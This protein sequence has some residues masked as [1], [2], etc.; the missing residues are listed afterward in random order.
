VY[1]N[2]NKKV[3]YL[4]AFRSSGNMSIHNNFF[5]ISGYKKGLEVLLDSLILSNCGHLIRSSSNVGAAAQFLNLNLTH[6][7]VNELEAGDC[8]EQ[9]Y[10]L[11]SM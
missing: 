3:I 7:N 10:N 11:Y 9:E 8:R 2:L 5:E 1:N 4:D 6:T